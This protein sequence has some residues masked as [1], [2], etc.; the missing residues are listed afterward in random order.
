MVVAPLRRLLLLISRPDGILK[1]WCRE[2]PGSLLKNEPRH[3]WQDASL[4]LK[5]AY[6][7]PK[8]SSTQTVLVEEKVTVERKREE[9]AA[10]PDRPSRYEPVRTSSHSA[11]SGPPPSRDRDT[12]GDHRA[13]ASAAAVEGVRGREEPMEREESTRKRSRFS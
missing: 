5:I 4:A 11:M 2:P 9:R 8:N 7:P 10:P 12:R 13:P 3:D 1:F 6:G